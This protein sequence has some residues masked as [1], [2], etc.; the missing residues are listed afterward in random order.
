MGGCALFRVRGRSLFF[1]RPRGSSLRPQWTGPCW[2]RQRSGG[3]SRQSP[4]R[5]PDSSSGIVQPWLRTP[6][7]AGRF[8]GTC[9]D[10][11]AKTSSDPE[12]SL[13]DPACRTTDMP[14]SGGCRRAKGLPHPI[15]V[16]EPVDLGKHMTGRNRTLQIEIIEQLC[17]CRLGAH[18][19]EILQSP[20]NRVNQTTCRAATQTVFNS[21]DVELSFAVL[22]RN[23]SFQAFTRSPVIER[24]PPRGARARC[25]RQSRLTLS[26]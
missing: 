19:D 23:V 22:C 10:D 5:A 8:P 24:A 18:H 9:H 14:S 16:E 11:T 17:W 4:R 12:P 15:H 2:R 1:P 3:H 21:I 25:L 7:A 20:H 26:A 13:P 6:A